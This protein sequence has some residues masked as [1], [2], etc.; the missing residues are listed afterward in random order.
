MAAAD[1]VK[2]STEYGAGITCHAFNKEGTS[3][4]SRLLRVSSPPRLGQPYAR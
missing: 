2:L 1:V 3:T 4:C